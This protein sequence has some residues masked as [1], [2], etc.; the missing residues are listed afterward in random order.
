MEL[1]GVRLL[2]EETLLWKILETNTY[3]GTV[4]SVKTWFDA[5]GLKGGHMIPPLR[6]LPPAQAEQLRGRLRDLGVV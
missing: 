6:D 4:S 1:N 5:I 3:A 2:L